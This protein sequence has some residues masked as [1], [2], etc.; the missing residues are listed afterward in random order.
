MHLDLL[1]LGALDRADGVEAI[2]A[3]RPAS[4][5]T[6]FALAVSSWMPSAPE[7]LDDEPSRRPSRRQSLPEPPPPCIMFCIAASGS[8]MKLTSCVTFWT[9]A[10]PVICISPRIFC[11]IAATC[12][13]SISTWLVGSL[14][15]ERMIAAMIGHFSGGMAPTLTL[16]PP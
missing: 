1:V 6:W 7:P 10:P 15:A 4:T 11:A 3:A 14:A 9:T 5:I 13:S 16:Q 2:D 12:K 8:L